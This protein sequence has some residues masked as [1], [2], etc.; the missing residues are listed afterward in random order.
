MSIAARRSHRGDEY[1]L[2][3]A[4]HWIIQLLFEDEGL[5]WVRV[6]PVVIPGQEDKVYVDDIV[7]R[8][9]NGQHLYIQAKKNQKDRVPWSIAD[10]ASEL[11]KAREQIENDP[12]GRVRFYSRTPFGAFDKLLEDSKDYEVYQQFAEHAPQTLKT[13]LADFA[14]AI[15]R[16]EEIA[17]TL[18]QRI[19]IGSHHSFDDWERENRKD[20]ERQVVYPDRALT[21][22]ERLAEK[23]QAGLGVPYRITRS[24]V[25]EELKKQGIVITPYRTEA[26]I[27]QYFK[28]ASSIGKQ[29]LSRKIANEELPREEIDQ[30]IEFLESGKKS[31]LLTDGPGTG[32]SWI[33]LELADRLEANEQWGMLFLK[34]DRHDDI[35]SE[36]ALLDRLHFPGDVA[37][38]AARLTAYR[39]VVVILD[40]L[41]ALSLSKNQKALKVFL[42]LLDRLETADGVQIVAACR[43]F[44]LV[45]DPNLRLRKW[46]KKVSISALD[47]ETVVAPILREKWEIDINSV[48]E[49]Q[50]KLLTIPRNLK[51]FEGFVGK[52]PIE[53][54][55]SSYHFLNAFLDEVIVKDREFGTQALSA[56]QHMAMTLLKRRSLFMPKASFQGDEETYHFLLSHEVLQLDSHRNRLGFVHQT[57]LDTVITRE[58]LSQNETLTSFILQYP[59][60]PFIRPSVRTFL[61]SLRAYE[62]ERFASQVKRVLDHPDI[63]YHLKRL[64][65]ESLAEIQPTSDD[66]PLLQWLL[67][68][69]PIQFRYFLWRLESPN[70]FDL[71]AQPLFTPIVVTPED[72]A[73]KS[74]VIRRLYVWMNERPREIIA[75]WNKVL[76]GNVAIAN[77]IISA[78]EKFEHWDVEGV[79]ELLE[80][81]LSI[82]KSQDTLSTG[83][84]LSKYVET[85]GTGYDMLWSFITAKIDERKS[86]HE[87]SVSIEH[88]LRCSGGY[89]HNKN[90]LRKSFCISGEFLNVCIE[91]LEKW[92]AACSFNPSASTLRIGFLYKT[93]WERVH[94]KSEIYGVSALSDLLEDVGYALKIRSEGYDKWWQA[95]EPMLRATREASLV[96]LLI[97]AYRANIEQNVLKIIEFLRREEIFSFD[98]LSYEVGELLHE[99]FP[100]FPNDV[101]EEFQVK[102]LNLS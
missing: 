33:L 14:T 80:S 102:I 46:G 87:L 10:L 65:A 49:E 39:K 100:S 47:F 6:D 11:R 76:H 74:S 85:T 22:I 19:D 23:N 67:R 93:S 90:F 61:F 92:S 68:H 29:G 63:A 89:F 51:L 59:P 7:V 79:R 52:V 62:P 55:T 81:L 77:E 53:F 64:I 24:D 18:C 35:E 13:T 31:V 36:Q 88:E 38:L 37:T 25:V 95:N 101:Q 42:A 70:W 73:I 32:K 48:S 44:D 78:L 8:Y 4:V 82:E 5:E 91:A 1:Q 86:R 97:Q 71:L 98:Q 69:H 60:L 56:I 3:I 28:E 57:L 9:R 15:Q 34:G 27:L 2:Y 83:K 16:T 66:L 41:D 12:S 43:D 75:F 26:E 17:Y 30:I 50:Q 40:S 20:L 84:A 45:Y 99:A 58:A 54:L 96:Y 72:D 21:V 94:H